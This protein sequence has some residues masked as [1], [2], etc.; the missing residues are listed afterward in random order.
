[1]EELEKIS[2]EEQLPI[3]D[4]IKI[5]DQDR[6]RLAS[7]VHLTSEANLRLAKALESMIKPYVFRAQALSDLRQSRR[8]PS[9]Q[10]NNDDPKDVLDKKSFSR[11]PSTL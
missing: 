10:T 3:V 6:R 11:V 4:N 8:W 5:V 7:W 2:K 1:M 9:I